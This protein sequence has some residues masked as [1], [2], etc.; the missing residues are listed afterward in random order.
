MQTA[1]STATQLKSVRRT[2]AGSF[3]NVIIVFVAQNRSKL[4]SA[5]GS[6]RNKIKLRPV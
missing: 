4:K 6:Q 2:C 5:K 1:T 3:A